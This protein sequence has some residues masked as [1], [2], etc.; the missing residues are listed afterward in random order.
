MEAGEAGDEMDWRCDPRGGVG[1]TVS[2]R[3]HTTGYGHNAGGGGHTTGC[4]HGPGGRGLNAHCGD[5]A[6]S[7]IRE[8]ATAQP[9]GEPGAPAAFEGGP[10]SEAR[11]ALDTRKGTDTRCAG[12]TVELALDEAG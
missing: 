1:R 3:G 10:L 4:G 11:N 12:G 2:G 8:I 9:A 6:R 5:H 7:N